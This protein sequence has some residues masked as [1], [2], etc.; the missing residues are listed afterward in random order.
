MSMNASDN[1][2]RLVAAIR[3]WTPHSLRDAE[4]CPGFPVLTAFAERRL[5]KRDREWMIR[6]LTR[7]ERCYFAISESMRMS[8]ESRDYGTW[9]HSRWLWSGLAASAAAL[10][11]STIAFKSLANRDLVQKEQATVSPERASEQ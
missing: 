2:H 11:L 9:R 4:T 3:W 7:C 5:G 10:L 6:H 1:P 8:G